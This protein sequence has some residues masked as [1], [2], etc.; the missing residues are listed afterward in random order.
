MDIAFIA[1]LKS[2][3]PNISYFILFIR[4]PKGGAVIGRRNYTEKGKGKGET[5]RQTKILGKH[6][7][8]EFKLT[9]L[10]SF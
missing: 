4:F 7:T 9:Q 2:I 6:E 5:R 1:K 10:L 8:Y 3:L